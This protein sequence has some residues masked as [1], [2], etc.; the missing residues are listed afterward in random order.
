MTGDRQW[1]TK[2]VRTIAA[3]ANAWMDPTGFPSAE[4]SS[5]LGVVQKECQGIY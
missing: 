4:G 3:E 1:L 5:S 2:F